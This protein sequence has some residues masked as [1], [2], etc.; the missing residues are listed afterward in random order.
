M[1]ELLL[2]TVSHIYT[3]HKKTQ[4]P[5]DPKDLKRQTSVIHF[6]IKLK[7]KKNKIKHLYIGLIRSFIYIPWEEKG[8]EKKKKERKKVRKKK[9]E[10]ILT[11]SYCDPSW[12]TKMQ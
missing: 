1:C 5:H 2:Y 7:N 8:E 6:I 10:M 4:P 9:S 12:R 3:I 11:R